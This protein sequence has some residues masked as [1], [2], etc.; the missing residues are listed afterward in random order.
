[1]ASTILPKLFLCTV[2]GQVGSCR[3][4]INLLILRTI[5]YISKTDW[6]CSVRGEPEG[7]IGCPEVPEHGSDIFCPNYFCAHFIDKWNRAESGLA[8]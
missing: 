3:I 2:C 6:N 5:H 8:Y 1:M 4:W 7:R